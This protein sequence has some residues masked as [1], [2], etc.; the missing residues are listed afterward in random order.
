MALNVRAWLQG[1]IGIA[2]TT[3]VLVI[4]FAY[5]AVGL[6]TRSHPAPYATTSSTVRD[7]T[8]IYRNSF[9]IPHIIA[10]TVNDAVFAQG[11]VHAQDRLWQIDV[12]RRVGQGRLAEILGKIAA[13]AD[14]FMRTL[15]IDRISKEQY[16]KLP[17]ETKEQLRAYADGVN[18]FIS[19]NRE[20]LPFEFDA[21]G[22]QPELWRPEDCLAVGRVMSFELSRAF[23]NDIAY[24]QIAAQRGVAAMMD[25]VPRGPHA[26]FILDSVSQYAEHYQPTS[27]K[28]SATASVAGH[29]HGVGRQ[30]ALVRDILGLKGSSVGSNCWAVGRGE[31]GAILANDPHLSVSMPAKWYQIHLTAP[32]LNVI[33]LSIPGIPFVLSGRNDHIAWGVTNALI[34]DVDF[35]IE[36][37][38]QQNP[39]YYFN[40]RGE[41][42]K[43]KFRRDTIRIKNEPDS[44]I[45]LRYTNTSCV[46]SDAHP[47]RSPGWVFGIPRNAAS[48]LLSNTCLTFRWTASYPSNEVGALYRINVAT[49]YQQ[50]FDALNLWN[51]P[52]MNFHVA[53]KDGTVAS[54]VAGV[55]P[56]RV[57]IDPLLPGPSWD[58]SAGWAGLIHLKALGSV[59]KPGR[60]GVASAN[61]R[62]I[63]SSTP[64]ISTIQEPSSRIERISELLKVYQE[65]SV[66]DAQV[67]QQDV[68]SPYALRFT[69]QLIPHLEKAHKQYTELERTA[70]AL[71][72]K[73]DGQLT[74][75]D[76]AASIHAVLLQRLVWN[77]FEDE[78]GTQLF[79]DWAFIGSNATKRIEELLVDPQH[80][81]FDDVR[82]KA[83]ENL[84]WMVVRS[85]HEAVAEL[86]ERFDVDIPSEWHYGKLH[87][88]TFPHLFGN[89]AL[90]R[91]V[92]N[93]GPYEVG[94]STTTIFNTEWAYHRPYET[95][96]TASGRVISDL[97]DSVQYT[98]LPGGVSGQPLDP[99][100]TDQMQLWLKGGYVRVPCSRRPDVTFRLFEI[101]LPQG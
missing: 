51:V 5:F 53:Q 26:P 29:I 33:G 69:Q 62:P 4:S 67:M 100:Y 3:L 101:L 1:T 93:A 99:H 71:L 52:A 45:D 92:M 91:P 72:K 81:L 80:R 64:F 22:Y 23:F 75:I 87:T 66:R 31:D 32:G 65:M 27:M 58:P 61:N 16:S 73:W 15:E 59:V 97:A 49:T 82:T 86:Q 46:I 20:E 83:R 24:A 30:L 94:G 76:P 55:I 17:A 7:T 95:I 38:D 57:G 85:F 96:I 13:P 28:D 14:A 39:N 8:R 2:V 74:T 77:T 9:G 11:Y 98:V 41:R 63:A 78:L 70:F 56:H 6:A 48:K 54:V 36:R 44:L 90:M 12:W 43:F 79:Y 35:V 18:S 21:L 42:V 50:V 84:T 88:V 37:V 25:Y 60:G 68:T 47:S 40:A 10:T 89:H 34:D 19:A